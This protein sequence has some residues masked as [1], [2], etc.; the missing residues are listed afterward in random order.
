MCERGGLGRVSFLF[1]EEAAEIVSPADSECGG[2]EEQHSAYWWCV[3]T[4]SLLDCQVQQSGKSS[5]FSTKLHSKHGNLCLLLL[6]LLVV[7]GEPHCRVH[8]P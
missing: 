3:H 4:G 1:D 5:Y 6:P 2:V 7:R 8:V